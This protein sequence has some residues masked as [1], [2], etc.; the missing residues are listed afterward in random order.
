MENKILDRYPGTEGGERK[1]GIY[2]VGPGGKAQLDT[3]FRVCF[4]N[5]RKNGSNSVWPGLEQ[6]A[7]DI[8]LCDERTIILP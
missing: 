8:L 1:I 3:Y 5:E 7:P 4:E 6:L 2:V